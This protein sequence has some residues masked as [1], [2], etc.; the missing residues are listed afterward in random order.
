MFFVF[1]EGYSNQQVVQQVLVGMRMSKPRNCPDKL[2]KLV[3]KCWDI[4]PEKRPTFDFLATYLSDYVADGNADYED[5]DQ[6]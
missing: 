5:P 3:Q 2:F 6:F 1:N 4:D